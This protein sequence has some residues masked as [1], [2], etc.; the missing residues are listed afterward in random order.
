M[1]H[2]YKNFYPV[3]GEM[4]DEW[5]KYHSRWE[6]RH[7]L[8]RAMEHWDFYAKFHRKLCRHLRAG[9]SLLDI[10]SGKGY[11]ALYFAAHG[12]PVTGIDFDVPSVEEANEWAS[13]LGLPARFHVCDIF[14]FQPEERYRISY[15]I[16]LIEH[17]APEEAR[18]LLAVQR[19]ASELI[20][21]LA[22]TRHSERTVE[23]CA[24]PWIPQSAATLRR[25]FASSGLNVIESF[26]CGDV[27]SKW[28]SRLK[29][30]LPHAA[31]HF[32]QNRL[33]YA[34]NVVTVGR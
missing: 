15:S 19:E 2:N 30:M 29:S 17:F 9:D 16:G 3:R 4:N 23:P 8:D 11:S 20:V 33:D 1:W 6:G 34:M 32:L 26:G 14:D 7:W 21:A 31:L 24:V 13:R 25:T 22:P 28:D 18:R 5:R 10:G 12:Y 27:S